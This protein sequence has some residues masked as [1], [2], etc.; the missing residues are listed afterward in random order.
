MTI[1][2]IVIILKSAPLVDPPSV[3]TTGK[4]LLDLVT[5]S[6]GRM[7]MMM[8]MLMVV[9]MKTMILLPGLLILIIFV[10]VKI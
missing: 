8:M 3:E 1:V 2:I 6:P 4:S 5:R 9:M 7:M 10:V